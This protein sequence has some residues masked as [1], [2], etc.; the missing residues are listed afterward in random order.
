[1]FSVSAQF[2][3]VFPV[4]M[5]SVIPHFLFCQIQAVWLWALDCLYWFVNCLYYTEVCLLHSQSPGNFSGRDVKFLIMVD[6]LFGVLLYSVCKY[7]IEK[8]FICF[9]QDNWSVILYWIFSWSRYHGNCGL[10]KEIRF[11][12]FYFAEY[13]EERWHWFFLGCLPSAFNP[14]DP[15]LFLVGRF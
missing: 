15:E 1:M 8:F 10:I 13:F 5:N 4:P 14:S 2:L 12:C 6:S 3:Q 11:F 7:F 9:H